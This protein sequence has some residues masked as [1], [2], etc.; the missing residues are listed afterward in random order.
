MTESKKTTKT[1]VQA[2]A[3]FQADLPPVDL[4]GVNP[5][6]KSKYAS[7]GNITKKV[8]PKLSEHGFAFSVGS[9]VDNGALILDAHLIHESGESRSAQFPITETNPQ[10]VGSAV[11]YY[12]RYA[13]AALTGIVAD[14]DDDGNAA[15]T[16]SAAER[17]IAKAA[18]R[19]AA[20]P[21][22]DAPAQAEVREWIGGDAD[23]KATANAAYERIK[24]E[25]GLTG[26]ALWE[27]VKAEVMK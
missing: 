7:L 26:T 10:K 3:A 18:S 21:A 19:P 15:S 4:D 17:Q 11:S 20:R 27:A 24:K 13:L 12:R 1:L 23:K 2:L 5:H 9:F 22:N 6:F 25:Q 16:P 14:E 8:F